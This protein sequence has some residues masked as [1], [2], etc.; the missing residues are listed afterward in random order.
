MDHI[1]SCRDFPKEQL[2]PLPPESE[3]ENIFVLNSWQ[4]RHAKLVCHAVKE[5]GEL[6]FMLC[7]KYMTDERFWH[8]YFSIMKPELPAEVF[9]WTAPAPGGGS[10]DANSETGMVEGVFREIKST[11]H[12]LEQGVAKTRASMAAATAQGVEMAPSALPRAPLDVPLPPIPAEAPEEPNAVPAGLAID[13]DLEA[14]LQV[15]EGDAED[16]TGDLPDMDFDDYLN[17]LAG[18]EEV[19]WMGGRVFV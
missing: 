6:R 13:P 1:L 3:S 5:M 8:I 2:L 11:W 17:E 18:P 10:K 19:R 12:T 14:Y 16:D 7:P 15:D 4:L 9:M